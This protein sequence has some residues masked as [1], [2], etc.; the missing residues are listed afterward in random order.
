MPRYKRPRYRKGRTVKRPKKT[1][2][3]HRVPNRTIE[4]FYIARSAARVVCGTIKN[5][6]TKA[7]IDREV[8]RRCGIGAPQCDCERA[9]LTLRQVLTMAASVG[10]LVAILNA[11]VVVP[12]LILSRVPLLGRIFARLVAGR[13]LQQLENQ[14]NTFEGIFVRV[15]DEISLIERELAR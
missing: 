6:A 4:R 7:E 10:I 3:C 2:H 9:L 13:A 14:A 8:Q 1:E 5:G 12:T 15:R 11:L